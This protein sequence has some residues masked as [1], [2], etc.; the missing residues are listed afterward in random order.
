[1]SYYPILS[2]PQCEGTTT[3]FNFAP[4]NWEE[5]SKVA[6]YLNAS[7][8]ERDVWRSCCLGVIGYGTSVSVTRAD[9]NAVLKNCYND[10]TF[11]LSLGSEPA[12]EVSESLPRSSI[13]I[14][15][16]PAW[17]ASL[18]LVASN[19]AKTSYQGEVDPFP[20]QGSLLTFGYFL[21]FSPE[22]SNSLLFIN[23]EK[24]PKSRRG[25]LEV[26]DAR[27]PFIMLAEFEV[28]TNQVNFVPLDN[29][30]FSNT[31][32]PLLVCRQMSGIPLFFSHTN[33]YG[34]L[35]LEHTHPPALS[36]INGDR[37][38]AQRV[39]KKF[40]FSQIGL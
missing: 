16:F 17:R 39:M 6:R 25:S 15:S 23:L 10:T 4:N 28:T 35:S 12:H 22:I 36:V 24:C 2:A 27:R 7:Y 13:P 5:T 31:S 37:F 38:G 8:I 19:G 32:L 30:G 33:D 14:T 9:V 18:G 26:R 21:Q 11:Y 29:L 3:I 1:M 20:S 40:W 34:S